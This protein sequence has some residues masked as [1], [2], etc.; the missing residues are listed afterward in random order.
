MRSGKVHIRRPSYHR[1][2]GHSVDIDMT[3]CGMVIQDHPIRVR[4][5]TTKNLADATCA[6]CLD[7]RAK[8]E[9]KW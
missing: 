7:I 6:R 8:S 2:R 4:V 3:Y 9:S 5:E 1:P